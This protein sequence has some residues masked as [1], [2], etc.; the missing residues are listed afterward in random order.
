MGERVEKNLTVKYLREESLHWGNPEVTV[1]GIASNTSEVQNAL[2]PNSGSCTVEVSR[3]LYSS[4]F[5]MAVWHSSQ[6]HPM[7]TLYV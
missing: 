7:R 2:L 1:V 4:L 6:V 3:L 5:C